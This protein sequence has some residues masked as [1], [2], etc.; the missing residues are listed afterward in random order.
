[1]KRTNAG[2]QGITI[3]SATNVSKVVPSMFCLQN[4]CTISKVTHSPCSTR[5]LTSWLLWCPMQRPP[6]MN[7]P[8]EGNSTQAYGSQTRQMEKVRLA[9][10]FQKEIE[11]LLNSRITKFQVGIG[12]HWVI[13]VLEISH[14]LVVLPICQRKVSVR[15]CHCTTPS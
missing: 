5:G 3:W 14:P 8:V 1:M 7:R 10:T 2:Q 13:P 12:C 6:M 15:A 9:F 11:L 4:A